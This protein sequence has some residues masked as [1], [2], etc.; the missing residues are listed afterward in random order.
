VLSVACADPDLTDWAV[1]LSAVFL[2]MNIKGMRAFSDARRAL[3]ARNAWY[4][5]AD[6]VPMCKGRATTVWIDL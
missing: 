5:G 2:T 4:A 3:F 6:I 1:E